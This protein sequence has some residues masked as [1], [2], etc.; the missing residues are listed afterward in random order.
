[1]LFVLLACGAA[2]A[3]DV[4]LIGLIGSGAAVF[5]VDGGEPRTIK[6]G[7]T[8]AGVTL[9]SVEG[10]RATVEFEGKRRVL[11]LG[12]HYRGAGTAVSSG[13][14]VTLAAD[15]RGHFVSE[16]SINGHPMRFLVDTGATTIA[17]PAADAVR[18]G[19]NY[20][21]GASVRT[22]TAAGDASAFRVTLASVRLG[23]IELTNVEGIVIEDGLDIALLGMSFLNRLDMRQEGRTMTLIKRF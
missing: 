2:R 3:A 15:P 11:A 10:E 9:V 17:L 14:S 22:R 18:L 20:R 19:I 21:S 23:D 6:L 1:M 5:A 8:R 4:A 16:G 7:Q 12:Q 13:Q